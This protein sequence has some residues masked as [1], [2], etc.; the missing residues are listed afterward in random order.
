MKYFYTFKT[1][2]TTILL[3]TSLTATAQESRKEINANAC[4]AGS[5]YLAYP[6]PMQKSY[7]AA[8]AGYKPFYISH[9]GR[10]GSRYLIG[11]NDYDKPWLT[12]AHADSL[13]MLTPL[14]QKTLRQLAIIRDEARGR[15]GELTLLGAQQHKDI[16]LRMIHNFP[17][18]FAGKTH[19][20]AKSTVVIRCILSMENALQQLL[21]VNPELDIRHDAS[22]HD[23]YYMNHHD[24]AIEKI[25]KEALNNAVLKAFEEKHEHHDRLMNSLFSSKDYW[26][27][28]V[29]AKSL[30][31]ALF[32]LACSMQNT[33]LRDSINLFPLFTKDE[34]YDCWQ[35]SNAW[36]YVEYGPAKISKGRVPYSQCAL[37][38]NI[39]E[40]ADSCIRLPHPGATLRYGH[41]T[42]VMPLTC[43]MDL[44]GLGEPIVNP[45]DTTVDD[46]EALDD[47][48]WL[49]YRIFPMACNIQLVF[50][51]R[52]MTDQDILVKILRNENEARLPIPSDCAPYYHWKDVREYWERKLK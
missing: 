33:D 10:H 43:L 51:H 19:I 1:I 31:R 27:Q 38:R 30:N 16:A 29:D 21:V 22:Y 9:Y 24:D 13:G 3:L 8:P 39:I 23:M 26:Q 35:Q 50:Y 46:L 5:N 37:L 14:G 42:M 18:V 44:D 40:T 7:T 49:D 6:G 17:E 48:G 52:S 41:D 34:L 2:F 15:D 25:K 4:L 12:L 20:D 36:W 32:A 45:K 47:R 28:H 11:K